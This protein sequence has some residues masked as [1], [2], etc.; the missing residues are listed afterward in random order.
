[1]KANRFHKYLKLCFLSGCFF[2]LFPE[3]LLSQRANLNEGAGSALMQVG[4]APVW[5]QVLG[6]LVSG[7]PYLQAESVVVACEGGAIRSF[8]RTGSPLW[9]FDPEIA[10]TPFVA[11][12]MEGATYICDVSGYF[13]AIN[14]VGR[15][16]WRINLGGPITHPPVVGWDGRV[17][18][19]VESQLSCR[20]ASGRQL[21]SIDLDSPFALSPRLDRIGS[22][23]TVLQNRD[24][25]KISQFSTIDRIRLEQIPAL[26]VSMINDNRKTYVLLYSN[27]SAERINFDENASR[28]NRLSRDR[29]PSLPAPPAEAMGREGQFVVTLRD[30]RVLFLNESGQVLWTGNS[31]ETAAERGPANLDTNQATMVFDERG[32][33]SITT[34]G[35]TGFAADGRRR[36]I[37]RFDEASSI[38]A[39][40]DE[41]LLYVP[42]RDQSLHTYKVESRPRTIPRTRY[43]GHAPEGSYGMGNPPPSPWFSDGRRFAQDEQDVMLIRIENAINSGQIG[44]REPA[45]VAY[46]MEMIGFFLNDPH[47]SRVRPN[48]MPERHIDL[49]RL[50]G[51]IG[52]R[53]TVPFLWNIFD[54]YH[55]STVRAA[56]AE[57]IGNIGVDPYG[58]T[59]HS[60]NFL[61]SANNPNR[62]P[63]LLMSA[64]T[65]IAALSRFS[66]PP[67][68]G[69]GIILLRHFSNLTWAPVA[70]RNQIRM[71]LEALFR[72]GLDQ[73]VR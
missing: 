4:A 5:D 71:E 17:F 23:V 69:E 44:E 42:G 65:A 47:Y 45:Y 18:I 12:S 6:D 10:A 1:M 60:F 38:P 27:G 22:V 9:D 61:L 57:A 62:D 43:Y 24:F 39:F 28:G 63:R 16:L 21:W 58:N 8:F 68:S 19:P 50:L 20:T 33:Y 13:R 7:Q 70:I 49:I 41:G 48:V 37:L 15:E 64:T 52:S 72:E 56:A 34:R 55:D 46:L 67:L 66:G 31:H 11:R 30:G 53:E 14:R 26:I 35:M 29:F 54:R 32:I 51:R 25:V 36:F 3:N 73:P 2:L 59:F 40:S